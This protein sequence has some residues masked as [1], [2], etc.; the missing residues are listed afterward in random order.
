MILFT[1]DQGQVKTC[2]AHQANYERQSESKCNDHTC[3]KNGSQSRS[4]VNSTL[5][6]RVHNQS[7]ELRSK[8][9][10]LK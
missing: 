8:L 7:L 6:T 2:V 4:R 9:H 3:K 1:A 5:K 10:V